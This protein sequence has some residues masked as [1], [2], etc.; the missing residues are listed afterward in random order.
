MSVTV[1]KMQA[2]SDLLGK[3]SWARATGGYGEINGRD[4]RAHSFE[5]S[6]CSM[7]EA[8]HRLLVQG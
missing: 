5:A 1:D 2:P 8:L 7:V 6:S 4:D 3:C